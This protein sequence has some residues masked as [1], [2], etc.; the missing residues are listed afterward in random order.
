M[1]MQIMDSFICPDKNYYV[2][3]VNINGSVQT[4]LMKKIEEAD[5][6][7]GKLAVFKDIKTLDGYKLAEIMRDFE[8]EKTSGN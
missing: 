7:N 5:P 3:I 2:D 8:N 1:Q 6:E 4:M